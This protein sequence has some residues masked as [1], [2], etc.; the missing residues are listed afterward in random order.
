[1]TNIKNVTLNITMKSVTPSINPTQHSDILNNNTEL[2]NENIS[3]LYN[4]HI[5]IV[6]DYGM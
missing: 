4:K 5:T 6:N 3:G 2:I 1:M